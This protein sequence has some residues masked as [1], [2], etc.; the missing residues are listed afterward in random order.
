MTTRINVLKSD[1]TVPAG[2]KY[3]VCE[4][5]YR[6]EDGKIKGM[7]IFGFGPMKTVFDV[8]SKAVKDDILAADFRQNDKGYWEFASLSSTG[9]KAASA[10]TPT[11]A[12]QPV[13]ASRTGNWETTDERAARQVMIVRQSSISNAI[14]AIPRPD[15][16]DEVDIAEII[17]IAKMFEA[18]V[19]DKPVVTGE[20]E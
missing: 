5:G 7:R 6:T 18:Y 1:V 19:L 3:Q 12:Q 11:S 13:V 2:K 10:A 4:L 9:E 17:Q 8:A 15:T 20:V 14:N 16:F